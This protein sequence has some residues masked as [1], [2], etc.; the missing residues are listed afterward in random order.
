M[1]TR[2]IDAAATDG[3]NG[4]GEQRVVLGQQLGGTSVEGDGGS[5][6]ANSSTDLVDRQVLGELAD[7]EEEEGQVEEEE[8]ENQREVDPQRSQARR[9]GTSELDQM[10]LSKNRLR[11]SFATHKKMKVTMNQEAKKIPMALANCPG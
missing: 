2:L 5:D 8:E 6:E 3:D 10:D 7:H 9:G 1:K 4:E 11:G